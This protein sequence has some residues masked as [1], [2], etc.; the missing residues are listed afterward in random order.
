MLGFINRGSL[1][2]VAAATTL[3][4]IFFVGFLAGQPYSGRNTHAIA[5]FAYLSLLAFFFIAFLLKTRT[6]IGPNLV[7]T[8]LVGVLTIGVR[9]CATP[10]VP[11]AG[12][13]VCG[14][15]GVGMR[16]CGF[17]VALRAQPG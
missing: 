14:M 5:Y 4:F 17:L 6:N 15:C 9:R 2:Q 11:S 7:Y 12:A 1:S 10:Y 13:A 16:A 8:I 3:A